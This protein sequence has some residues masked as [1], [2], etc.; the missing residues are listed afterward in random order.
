MEFFHQ[1]I[2]QLQRQLHVSYTK[3]IIDL[4][5]LKAI[6]NFGDKVKNEIITVED[7]QDSVEIALIQA[8]YVKVAKSYMEIFNGFFF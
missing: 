4:L 6:S 2:S 5:T 3:D 1:Y 7:I 8:G